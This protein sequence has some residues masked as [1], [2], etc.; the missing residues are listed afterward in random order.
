[1]GGISSVMAKRSTCATMLHTVSA[2]TRVQPWRTPYEG[3]D[4]VETGRPGAALT[5]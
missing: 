2:A 1:M 4:W 5:A 3:S